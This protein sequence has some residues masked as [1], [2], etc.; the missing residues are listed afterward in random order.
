[1]DS[2]N[3]LSLDDSPRHKLHR[4]MSLSALSPRKEIQTAQKEFSGP[5]GNAIFRQYSYNELGVIPGTSSL[6]YSQKFVSEFHIDLAGTKNSTDLLPGKNWL[7]KHFDLNQLINPTEQPKRQNEEPEHFKK[8]ELH[9][10]RTHEPSDSN[11]DFQSRKL[12]KYTPV[13]NNELKNSKP[14]FK[15]NASVDDENAGHPRTVTQ[16][17]FIIVPLLLAMFAT[18]GTQY[19]SYQKVCEGTL[20]VKS[21]ENLLSSRI[22]GQ[23]KAVQKIIQNFK[24]FNS[25]DQNGLHV[26]VLNGPTGVGKTYTATL[27]EEIFPWKHNIHQF[28][29]PLDFEKLSE[30]SLQSYPF[31]G[32]HFVIMD[33]LRIEDIKDVAYIVSYLQRLASSNKVIALL[34]F[35]FHKQLS[36]KVSENEVLEMSSAVQKQLVE[37]GIDDCVMIDFKMLEKKEVELCIKEALSRH[38]IPVTEQAIKTILD[39][40]DYHSEG[41]KRI[42]SKIAVVNELWVR[43]P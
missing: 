18:F 16:L 5:L 43:S 35:K 38:W 21:I 31:C 24:N 6:R 23:E 9:R 42:S 14:E 25:S 7:D 20:D 1:M 41:C 33:D 15:Q 26:I 2:F 29:M 13:I 11:E 27:L 8:V 34:I 36:G 28:I 3:S 4:S 19:A 30:R 22:Y 39:Q 12:F 32:D 40:V 37:R 17:L 10:K